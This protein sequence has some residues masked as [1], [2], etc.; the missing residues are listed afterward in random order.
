MSEELIRDIL[1]AVVPDAGLHAKYSSSI[2]EAARIVLR[3]LSDEAVESV[4]PAAIANLVLAR[5][6]ELIEYR[7]AIQL[8]IAAALL[9]RNATPGLFARMLRWAVSWF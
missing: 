7:R 6:P 9:R 4:A 8:A 5:N 2:D 3:N 1:R